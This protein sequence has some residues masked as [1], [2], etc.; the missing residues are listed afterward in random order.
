MGFYVAVRL[1]V[2][3]WAD[4]ILPCQPPEYLGLEPRTTTPSMTQ[5]TI[6]QE[7]SI[8]TV[9]RWSVHHCFFISQSCLQRVFE[10]LFNIRNF[11]NRI[12]SS[13]EIIFKNFKEY[14]DSFIMLL[15]LE[16]IFFLSPQPLTGNPVIKNHCSAI[17]SAFFLF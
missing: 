11:V 6:T 12:F 9:G 2:K 15:A 4:I 16:N 17:N 13:Q 14:R 1:V 3:Y 7:A 8:S 10:L 5:E